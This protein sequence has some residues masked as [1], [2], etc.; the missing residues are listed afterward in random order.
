MS[1]SQPNHPYDED[2]LERM[3]RRVR[4]N[5]VLSLVVVSLAFVYSLLTGGDAWLILFLVLLG[6]P[7]L[8]AIAAAI[9]GLL[10]LAKGLGRYT[11]ATEELNPF[12]PETNYVDKPECK[13]ELEQEA[14]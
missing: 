6:L 2:P 11:E 8:F 13:A 12:V 3:F 10:A 5:I 9:L 7:V 1:G 14:D 4:E